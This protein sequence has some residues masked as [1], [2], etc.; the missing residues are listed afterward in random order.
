MT[1]AN[2]GFDAEISKMFGSLSLRAWAPE[3]SVPVRLHYANAGLG[4]IDQSTYRPRL[5][6]LYQHRHIFLHLLTIQ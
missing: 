4:E 1:H 3:P 5:R 6:V 2:D